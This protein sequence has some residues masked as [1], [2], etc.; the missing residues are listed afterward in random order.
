MSR[1]GRRTSMIRIFVED[2][3]LPNIKTNKQTNK[4]TK[5]KTKNKQKQQQQQQQQKTKTKNKQKTKTTTK[6][7]QNKT[8]Q[9]K[10]KNKQTKNKQTNK[11]TKHTHTQQNLFVHVSAIKCI[12]CDLSLSI[13][14]LKLQFS[15][16]CEILGK[17]REKWYFVNNR[18]IMLI[19]VQI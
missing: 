2:L 16:V 17:F 13:I 5:T 6:T 15:W 8:K 7:R 18:L 14:L 9:N 12:W 4:Q 3:Q 11:Q 19:Q 1:D 10:T